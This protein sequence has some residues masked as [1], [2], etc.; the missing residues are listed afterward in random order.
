MTARHSAP[1][2]KTFFDWIQGSMAADGL[3]VPAT[4]QAEHA[5][6]ASAEFNDPALK[7]AAIVLAAMHPHV[8]D[9]IGQAPVLVLAAT[10]E[11][12]EDMRFRDARLKLASRF[13]AVTGR[14]HRL[15]H[16]MRAYGLAPPL[17][18]LAG[19]TLRRSHYRLLKPLSATPETALAQSIPKTGRE[20]RAW[21]LWLTS[22]ADRRW[23][24]HAHRDRFL[25]WAAANL[26]TAEARQAAQD[27]VDW[28]MFD[29]NS[30]DPAMG[31]DQ[32]RACSARWHQQ[33]ADNR[34]RMHAIQAGRVKHS[35]NY[36]PLPAE[37]QVDGFTVRA[38]CSLADLEEEGA[39]M[40]HCVRTYWR[41]VATAR[42]Y[43][44]SIRQG[45]TRLAT[46]ELHRP[47]TRRKSDP[48]VAIAQIRGPCNASVA[49][50]ITLAAQRFLG[51]ANDALVAAARAKDESQN[52]GGN[53]SEPPA[54][55][56]IGEE[57]LAAV[58]GPRRG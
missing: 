55:P 35:V 41:Y 18:Q 48:R 36:A 52:A 32:A 7:E 22:L 47:R 43:I 56:P 27:L 19:G 2:G 15:P 4:W 42:S 54:K 49:R 31:Y 12:G 46:I 20:Q 34:R 38:L 51:M 39:R 17:R 23:T 8:L 40:H 11:I 57:A 28:V 44:Y 53:T 30:F 10:G 16:I 33:Q 58:R 50:E 45:D 29:G 6:A 13:I 1:I 37:T 3:I 24:R 14:C 9:Y 26:R 25:T 21:L 5:A